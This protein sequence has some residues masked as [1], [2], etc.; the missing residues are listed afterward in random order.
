MR[1][2]AVAVMMFAIILVVAN[3]YVI[4]SKSNADLARFEIAAIDRPIDAGFLT[5][6]E[7]E[8]I[9]ITTQMNRIAA[10]LSVN[11]DAA[12]ELILHAVRACLPPHSEPFLA[13][14][15]AK[16]VRI[17]SETTM[18]PES[19]RQAS[20]AENMIA[21]GTRFD[22]WLTD[23]PDYNQEPAYNLLIENMNNP[24]KLFKC[25][26]EWLDRAR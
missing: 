19:Q 26:N 22:R 8:A 1:Y 11:P 24:V 9:Q 10:Q 12:F 15:L 14:S 23:Q 7:A 25:N 3:E 17:L 2:I 20:I 21:L 4:G 6:S 13:E 5:L 16:F 18:L